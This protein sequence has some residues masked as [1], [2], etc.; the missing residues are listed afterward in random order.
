M[1][2]ETINVSLPAEGTVLCTFARPE[3]RNALNELMV[4]EI[5][6]LLR[7]LSEHRHKPVIIFAGNENVFVS[8]A[9]ISELRERN[10][11]DALRQINNGLFRAIEAYAGVTI[12]AIRGFALGG[13]CELAAACDFRV[14][15][16][17]AQLGQ[18]EVKLGIMPGAGATYRLPRLIG[19]AHAKDLVLTGRIVK[20]DEADRMGLV[21]RLVDD[22]DVLDEALVLAD[23]VA[24]NGSLAVQFSKMALNQSQEL[25]V[26]T[27]MILESSIQ[28]ILF[29]DDDKMT[30]MTNFLERK[31]KS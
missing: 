5:H 29:E 24:G 26:A 10:K 9:D 4:S 3:V 28:A 16:R 7:S 12:A 15:G 13:G 11:F 19:L 14:V 1:D 17:G 20:A 23:Q 2:Y 22:G 6:D 21:S 31:R 27:G 8:G 30:R 25:S 18:P